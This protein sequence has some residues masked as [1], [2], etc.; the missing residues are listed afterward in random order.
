MPVKN[1][2]VT[3]ALRFA[4]LYGVALAAIKAF[5]LLAT[6]TGTPT[7]FDHPLRIAALGAIGIA[8]PVF[9]PWHFDWLRSLACPGATPGNLVAAAVIWAPFLFVASATTAFGAHVPLAS[10]V[11]TTWAIAGM[12]ALTDRETP[13]DRRRRKRSADDALRRVV[14]SY[15]AVYGPAPAPVP[16]P[17]A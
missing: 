1:W 11:A 12:L 7:S 10:D 15:E 2:Y 6:L 3:R 16:I 13:G 17:R 5:A 9:A 14:A 8:W 4:I